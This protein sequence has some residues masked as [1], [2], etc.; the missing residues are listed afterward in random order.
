MKRPFALLAPIFVAAIAFSSPVQAAG[1]YSPMPQAVVTQSHIDQVQYRSRG[2]RCSTSLGICPLNLSGS[3]PLGSSCS[4][5]FPGKK[6]VA[7]GRTI[8]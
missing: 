5:R 2:G 4:C 6:A 8:R 1:P 7:A 3:K